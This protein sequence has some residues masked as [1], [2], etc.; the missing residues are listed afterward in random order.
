MASATAIVV[1]AVPAVVVA[2]EA[3][4]AVRVAGRVP[5]PRRPADPAAAV[6]PVDPAG[7]VVRAAVAD[8]AAVGRAARVPR[9]IAHVG[10]GGAAA[11]VVDPAGRRGRVPRAR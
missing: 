8:P 3:P 10:A 2:R 6:D 4:A 1:V 7:V 5:A 9:E 11:A